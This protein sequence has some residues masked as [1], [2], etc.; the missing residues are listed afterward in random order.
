MSGIAGVIGKT[1][2]TAVVESMLSTM[3]GGCF[4][5]KVFDLDPICCLLETGY[6]NEYFEQRI[7]SSIHY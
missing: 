3:T 2:E 7:D 1:T 4:A 6:G 5:G